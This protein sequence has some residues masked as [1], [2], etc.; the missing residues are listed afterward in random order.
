[1]IVRDFHGWYPDDVEKEVHAIVGNIRGKGKTD[2]VE[3]I[4]GRGKFRVMVVEILRDIYGLSPVY[5]LG[6]D[7]AIIVTIE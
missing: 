6:N 4:T 3:F 7:G 2:E 5:K 1:M